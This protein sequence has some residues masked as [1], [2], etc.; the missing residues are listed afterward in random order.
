M[1]KTYVV[2][3]TLFGFIAL[4]ASP[5]A[6]DYLIIGSDTIAIYSL[7][8]YSLPDDEVQ[9]FY[10]IAKKYEDGVDIPLSFNLWRGYNLLW[11]LSNNRLFLVAIINNKNSDTILK[12]CFSDRYTYQMV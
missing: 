4:K 1:S 10:D 12:E 2:C 11:E 6:P 9:K 5:Q 7:P 3:L 8:L